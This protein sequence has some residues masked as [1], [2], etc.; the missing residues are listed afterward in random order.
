LL[1]NSPCS[2]VRK[3]HLSR[4][5]PPV[6]LFVRAPAAPPAQNCTCYALLG[7]FL[8]LPVPACDGVAVVRCVC[9]PACAGK[10]PGVH[11]GPCRAAHPQDELLRHGG[12]HVEQHLCERV[13][14]ARGGHQQGQRRHLGVQG[15]S[16]CLARLACLL[17][18]GVGHCSPWP[19]PLRRALRSPNPRI[20]LQ[21][22]AQLRA[23]RC[24]AP[25]VAWVGGAGGVP[26]W[27]SP[28]AGSLYSLVFFVVA[29]PPPR[30][31]PPLPHFL[32]CGIVF[33]A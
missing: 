30:A 13:Q 27:L 23:V 16:T 31:H 26:S 5:P 12:V 14:P 11:D 25:V 17:A 18:V 29:P 4:A 9:L 19:W 28:V 2:M 8:C 1:T 15:T 3:S 7:A 22:I 20:L 21:H 24:A 33:P 32:P 10:L 6:G